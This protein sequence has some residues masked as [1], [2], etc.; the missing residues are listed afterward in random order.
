MFFAYDKNDRRVHIDKAVKGQDYFCPCCGASLLQKKGKIRQH[1]FSHSKGNLCT[2]TW[3]Y[4][5]T[6]WHSEWQSLFTDANQEVVLSH[7]NTK[8]RADVLVGRTV[9]EFQHSNISYEVFNERNDF[10]CNL[11]YKVIWVFD[12]MEEF[13]EGYILDLS[14]GKDPQNTHFGW[15]RPKIIFDS[16][17]VQIGQVDLFFQLKE[18]ETEPCLVKV[19]DTSKLRDGQFDISRWYSKTEFMEYLGVKN[20]VC[21]APDSNDP[22]ENIEFASFCNKYNILLDKHQALAVQAVEGANLLLAV[23]GSGKTTVLVDRIGF[24]IDCKKIDNIL[25]MTHSKAAAKD[26]RNR[27]ISIF[28]EQPEKRI[29]FCTIHSFADSV[30]KK[31]TK[32]FNSTAFEVLSEKE[33]DSIIRNILKKILGTFPAESDINQV[34][35]D[36]AYIKNMYPT[37]LEEL[38]EKKTFFP[39]INKVYKQYNEELSNLNKMDYYDQLICAFKILQE[40]S[41]ILDEFHHEFQYI[42]VDE[43]QD[44]SKIQHEII[45]LLVKNS[46]NIFM[47]GDEDQSIYGFRAAHPQALMDFKNYYPNPFILVMEKNYRSTEDIVSK[48][49]DFI[50]GHRISSYNKRFCA[51]RGHGHPVKCIHVETREE[52]YKYLLEIAKKHNG[53][54]CFSVPR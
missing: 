36:I 25:T 45:R 31:Y 51:A 20:G 2:D 8:H 7:E 47:V 16:R 41:D 39:D 17:S 23:P 5:M 27:F 53:K 19:I 12:F 34:K 30:I 24:M 49:A 9:V 29:E 21:A 22:F 11:G 4:N 32:K 43:A 6:P 13:K 1:H 54:Y 46:N 52:Q 37:K 26:M 38:A 15:S 44:L 50:K 40:H 18:S 28:G 3:Y 33:K 10:Y 35:N 48:A 42:C 14:Y